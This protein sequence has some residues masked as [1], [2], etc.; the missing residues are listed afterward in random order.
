MLACR[1]TEWSLAGWA[2]QVRLESSGIRISDL[3]VSMTNNVTSSRC[4]TTLKYYKPLRTHAKVTEDSLTIT[5]LGLYSNE[6][7]TNIS[8][9]TQDLE[10]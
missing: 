2:H 9:N 3:P 10:P 6:H 4:S 5:T 8:T 7:E 1:T